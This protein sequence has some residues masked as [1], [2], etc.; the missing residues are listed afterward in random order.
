MPKKKFKECPHCHALVKRENF[1]R[2][3]RTVHDETVWKGRSSKIKE[4]ERAERQR[5]AAAKQRGR[6]KAFIGVVAVLIVVILITSMYITMTTK[7]PGGGGGGGS[8]VK[9]KYATIETNKGTFKILLNIEKAPKTAGNFISLAQSGFYGGT[10]FHRVVKDFVAQGGGY[11][12]NLN[13]KSASSI[14][15][16][17]TGLKNIRYS[18]AMARSGNPDTEEGANTASSQFFINLRDNPSLDN[19]KY[20]FVV[21]GQVASGFSVVDSI[22]NAPTHF[23]ELSDPENPEKSMPDETILITKVTISDS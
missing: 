15:F 6:R 8:T 12:Q 16:E 13:L 5:L 9:N 11:D 17:A 7:Q 20:P 23:S 21:F 3:L 18:I 1:D 10:I 2:H 19:Y 14:P 4:K 22:G